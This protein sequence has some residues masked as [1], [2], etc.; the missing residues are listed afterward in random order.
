MS[1]AGGYVCPISQHGLAREQRLCRLWSRGMRPA[2]WWRRNGGGQEPGSGR[3]GP[4]AAPWHSS[5]L[6]PAGRVSLAQ[7]ALAFVTDTRGGRACCAGPDCSFTGCC[8][9]ARPRGVG[10]GPARIRPGP[11][12]NPCSSGPAVPAWLWP[13]LASRCQDGS[14]SRPQ[15]T[16][17]SWL[18]DS[19]KR[20]SLYKLHKAQVRGTRILFQAHPHP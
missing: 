7:F 8:S 14:P 1:R 5:L 4:A 11:R 9:G 16:W 17:D 2:S 3:A 20:L 18:P 15:P 13:F 19:R 6:S 12:H 10:S